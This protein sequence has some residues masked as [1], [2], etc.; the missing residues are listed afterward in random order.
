ML[1]WNNKAVR[2]KLTWDAWV[3]TASGWWR[4]R[5]LLDTRAQANFISQVLAKEADLQPTVEI[6]PTFKAANQA[7]IPTY[8]VYNLTAEM[9]D[10]KGTPCQRAIRLLAMDMEPGYDMILGIPWYEDEDKLFLSAK[11]YW[12]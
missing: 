9:K 2:K 3:K 8:G 5:A 11:R 12:R 7:A 4:C 10:A 1:G 6:A